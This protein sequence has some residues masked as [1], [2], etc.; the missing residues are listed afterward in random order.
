[1]KN[2]K[3]AVKENKK[4]YLQAMDT[5][6]S[7]LIGHDNVLVEI[8]S[9]KKYELEELKSLVG[10]YIEIVYNLPMNK[11]MVI[12]EEGKLEK[13]PYN[14]YATNLAV[15]NRCIATDDYIAGNAVIL[16]SNQID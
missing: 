15:L 4:M 1:M 7:F 11:M 6:K 14:F 16:N 10:G 13:L 12:N 8:D 5:D 3:N 2:I 9:K